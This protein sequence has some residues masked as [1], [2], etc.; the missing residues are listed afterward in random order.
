MVFRINVTPP[1]I[2]EREI[3]RYAG[4]F[5]KD[6]QTEAL[7]QECLEEAKEIFA[8]RICY[9]FLEEKSDL[10]KLPPLQRY[11]SSCK[12]RVVFAATVGVEIDRLIAK[13]GRISPAK[14]LM[15]Q[16]LGT[17][18]VEALCDAFCK[19]LERE[20]QMKALRRISPGYGEL[21]LSLQKEIFPLLDC[22]RQIGLTLG[23]SLL[24]S[25]TKSVTA[26]VG[27]KEQL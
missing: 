1:P 22:Q 24:M 3:L 27:L 23:S 25:P 5:E 10:L 15:F 13:Y 12:K 4:S 9:R 26:F 16:A 21:P 18:R 2:C 11:F 14:A 19:E 6:P 7:L 17:E 20:S 8:Y